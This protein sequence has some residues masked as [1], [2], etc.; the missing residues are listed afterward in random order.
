VPAAAVLLPRGRRPRRG[1]LRRRR[2]PRG[3]GL[4]VGPCQRRAAAAGS[5]GAARGA[6]VALCG[7]GG[8]RGGGRQRG[9][10]RGGAAQDLHLPRGTP[11]A[12]TRGSPCNLQSW[13]SNAPPDAEVVLVNDSNIR[14]LVPDLPEEYWRL[15][16]SAAKSDVIRASVL[17]HHGG[18]YIDTDFL[19]TSPLSS[20]Q[21]RLSE[22]WDVVAYAAL[23]QGKL[24]QTGPCGEDNP[25]AFASN[26]LAAR[27]GNPWS[28]TWW[29]NIKAKLTRVCEEK[30]LGCVGRVCCHEGFAAEPEERKCHIPWAH[31]EHL[32]SPPNDHDARPLGTGPCRDCNCVPPPQTVPKTGPQAAAIL[33][34]VERGH[35]NATA[36]PPGALERLLCLRGEDDGVSP[37]V[38]GEVYWQPWD[39]DRGATADNSSGQWSQ[40]KYEHQYS[41]FRNQTDL[42]CDTHR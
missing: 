15:P 7:R 42:V 9:G 34:A 27:R 10:R 41:C 22:G 32:K 20:V 23:G 31:L 4:V 29:E 33:A 24:K 35:R 30:Q 1:L 28:R 36:L 6:G 38:Y 25:G 39:A 16:Y 14:S 17:Y 21:R 26:F 19:V 5:P 3:G 37:H 18:L 11:A 2:G 13:R 40:K 8:R 12:R